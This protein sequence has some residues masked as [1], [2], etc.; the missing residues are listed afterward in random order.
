[1]KP[2]RALALLAALSLT[3]CSALMVAELGYTHHLN[4][5]LPGADAAFHAGLGFDA[6]TSDEEPAYGLGFSGRIRSYG[7]PYTT[8]EPG[9]HA[10][11]LKDA[12]P[13]SYYLRGTAY[14][15]MSF[16]KGYTSVVFSPTLQPGILFC[17]QNRIG[18]CGSLSLPVSY[19]LSSS[20]DRPGVSL[21]LSFGLGWGNVLSHHPDVRF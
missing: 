11:V 10:Y 18:W 9:L 6:G 5:S 21:G 1:M 19:D 16:L 14:A 17:P 20:T 13:L 12:G 3:G 7:A 4:G 8:I 15:G 2:L